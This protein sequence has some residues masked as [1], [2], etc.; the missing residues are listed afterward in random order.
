MLTR[1]LLF[2]F[3]LHKLPSLKGIHL[4][5][6]P[7]MGEASVVAAHSPVG[8]SGPTTE[9]R[10]ERY[11]CVVSAQLESLVLEV[12]KSLVMERGQEDCW[13]GR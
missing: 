8:G 1:G 6:S 9:D 10:P 7:M 13:E 3:L 2:W 12:L 5:L 11:L 4:K